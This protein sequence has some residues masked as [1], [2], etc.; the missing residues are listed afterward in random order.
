MH[1]ESQN[2]NAQTYLDGNGK[3]IGAKFCAFE[4]QTVN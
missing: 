2:L 3:H 4:I 1:F